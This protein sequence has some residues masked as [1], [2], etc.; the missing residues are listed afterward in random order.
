MT[1]CISFTILGKPMG[2]ARPRV[3]RRGFAYTPAPTVIYENLVK[4]C[5][6]AE[7]EKQHW[8]MADGEIDVGIHAYFE[9]PKST[10]KNKKLEMMRGNIRP[11]KKPDWD[12][13]GKII[14]DAI[15]GI[16]YHDDSQIVDACVHKSYSTIGVPYVIVK[17]E[18]EE[19]EK[20]D[21]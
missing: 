7:A 19:D 4:T 20:N 6:A 15:N 10:S 16:A 21:R 11:T 14:C 12:N 9:I 13:I 3:T 17:I 18:K 2:K 5:F 1:K 8:E